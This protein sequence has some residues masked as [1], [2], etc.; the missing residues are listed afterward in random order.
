LAWMSSS[1]LRWTQGAWQMPGCSLSP[2]LLPAN[3]SIPPPKPTQPAT[4][5]PSTH[6]QSTR[7]TPR[8]WEFFWTPPGG[9][10]PLSNLRSPSAKKRAS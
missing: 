3:T 9:T 5:P 7:L 2:S 8:Q 1:V 4:E 10:F 6:S